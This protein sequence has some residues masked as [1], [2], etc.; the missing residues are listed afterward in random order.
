MP[1]KQAQTYLA[2]EPVND[3]ANETGNNWYE[4]CVQVNRLQFMTH[5]LMSE[6][7]KMQFEL[8]KRYENYVEKGKFYF[9]QRWHIF[10]QIRVKKIEIETAIGLKI[11]LSRIYFA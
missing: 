1:T 10:K 6:E 3:L 5:F 9:R 11:L 4:L 7:H 2:N 8:I